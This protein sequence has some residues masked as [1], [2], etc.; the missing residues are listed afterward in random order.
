MFTKLLSTLALFGC[1]F[2]YA[3]Q[4]LHA[5]S[6][7]ILGGELNYECIAP[8]TYRVSLTVINDCQATPL[9][10]SLTVNWSGNCPTNTTGSITVGKVPAATADFSNF[11]PNGSPC[12]GGTGTY[13]FQSF[14]YRDTLTLSSTCSTIEL[15]WEACCYSDS[16]Q[17]I[18]NPAATPVR[19]YTTL[20]N[21]LAV[22]NN[23]PVFLNP[24]L[25]SSCTNHTAFFNHGIVDFD[26]DSLFYS[27]V[28]CQSTNGTAINYNNGFST[29]NPLGTNSQI[30]IDSLT[31][32]LTFS[33]PSP[34]SGV[35]CVLVKEKRMGVIISEMIRTISIFSFN[36]PVNNVPT[37]TGMDSSTVYDTTITVG[38]TLCFKVYTDDLD[39]A[40]IVTLSAN[41]TAFP[42][43]TFTID[44]TG[45]HPIGTFCWTPTI[46]DTGLH[47][48][49]IIAMDN[50][51]PFAGVSVRSFNITVNVPLATTTIALEKSFKI[52][53]NPAHGYVSIDLQELAAPSTHVAIFDALGQ[54][55]HRQVI[56]SHQNISTINISHLNAGYYTL[57]LLNEQGQQQSRQQLMIR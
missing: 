38:Q 45:A 54:E 37:I 26:G 51:S 56:A 52:F 12:N 27:L 36:C 21:S 14:L 20:D 5:Q 33:T 22:C 35:I 17:N 46:A 34:Q 2:C 30:T 43:A 24:A 40:D 39:S 11:F 25:S 1:L 8:N 47:V 4:P 6:H 55:V 19:L 23:S 53:P 48:L 3:L 42:T 18:Q 15:S 31:G 9:P 44:T 50:G 49:N 29:A 41:L 10:D 32:A 7:G 16:L 57:T 28:D 13:G